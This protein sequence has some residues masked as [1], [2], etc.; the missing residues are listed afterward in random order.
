MG[1]LD[2]I[3]HVL[4]FIAPALGLAVLSASAAKLVWRRDLAGVAW[5]RLALWAALAGMAVLI[6][7]L[8]V[9]GRDGKM[10]TYAAL[11]VASAIALWIAGFV[12]R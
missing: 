9:F 2:A 1:S 12:R 7:G 11:V 5:L 4:N 6:G 8:V 10:A 3:W